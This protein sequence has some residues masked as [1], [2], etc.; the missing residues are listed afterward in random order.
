M[1]GRRLD[2]GIL[3][4]STYKINAG[5]AGHQSETPLSTTCAKV[6]APPGS[7]FHFSLARLEHPQQLCQV[8]WTRLHLPL[9]G[10]CRRKHRFPSHST[11]TGIVISSW[12]G[13]QC[14]LNLHTSRT[15]SWKRWGGEHC[16]FSYHPLT[17]LLTPLWAEQLHS[18]FLTAIDLQ[19]QTEVAASVALCRH[20]N[21]ILCNL[22]R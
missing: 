2:I 15:A 12:Y 13:R 11:A 18:L 3:P 7:R 17:S 4:S 5:Q 8:P 19:T 16:W 6:W 20:V 1:G 10:K 14:S 22:S 9:V 21:N